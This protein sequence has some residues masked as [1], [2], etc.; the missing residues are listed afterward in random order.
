MNNPLEILTTLDR[1]LGGPAELTLFG[2]AA[3][4]L[5][6]SNPKAD[7][8]ATHDVDGIIPITHEGPNT[9]FWLAQRATNAELK[10]R[11]LY[12]T[13]LFSELALA[14]EVAK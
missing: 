14:D 5:G 13:H 7:Y 2:R 4:A 12:I 11:G 8:G 6:Y 10:R 9:D 1:H 3:L